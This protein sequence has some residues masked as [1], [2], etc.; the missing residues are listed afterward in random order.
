MTNDKFFCFWVLLFSGASILNAHEFMSPCINARYGWKM[1][2]PLPA[3]AARNP[4]HPFFAV[5]AVLFEQTTKTAKT[6]KKS[7]KP[8]CRELA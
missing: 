7:D 6:A 1:A 8:L 2:T 4:S 3:E 5:F